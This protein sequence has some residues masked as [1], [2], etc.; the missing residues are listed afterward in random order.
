MP[1][2]KSPK[3][4]PA[5]SVTISLTAASECERSH[6]SVDLLRRF[7]EYFLT[8]FTSAEGKNGG[9]WSPATWTAIGRAKGWRGC[10]NQYYSPSC[11]MR[12]LFEKLAPSKCRIYNPACGSGGMFVQW[13]EFVG[14]QGGNLDN[15]SIYGQDKLA[16][17]QQPKQSNATTHR[18]GLMNRA[19][20]GIEAD[21]DFEH[22]DTFCRSSR[23]IFLPGFALGPWQR[24]CRP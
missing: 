22:A 8:R 16:R 10:A 1:L 6:R 15:I 3:A 2:L 11:D 21:L 23:V 9:Q 19:L 5:S 7:Y 18:L 20:R 14:S 17:R 4:S 12:C 13:D 24:Q